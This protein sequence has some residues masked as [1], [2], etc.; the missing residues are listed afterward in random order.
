VT[1]LENMLRQAYETVARLN[2]EI[3]ALEA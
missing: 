2:V 1:L 3:A